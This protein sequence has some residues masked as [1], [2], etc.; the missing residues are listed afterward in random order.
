MY[1][2]ISMLVFT[3]IPVFA[4]E[5]SFDAKTGKIVVGEQFQVD[6]V[7]HTENEE[8]NA[9]EGLVTFSQEFLEL[10]EIRDGNSFVNFWIERPKAGVDG[11]IIFSGITPGGYTSDKGF[12][13]SLIFQA[14]KSGEGVI[15]LESA[16]VLK[17]D[18]QGTPAQVRI[19][20]YQFV[21]RP[22]ASPE[23]Q[24]GEQDQQVS[25]KS[26]QPS[27][28]VI[29]DTEL[30]ESFVPEIV[31]TPVLFEGDWVA[32]FATQDKKSGIHYYEIKETRQRL[33]TF[34]SKWLPAES[35][36]V[37]KDQ[38]L[39][40]SVFVKAVDKAGNERVVK[41]EPR[42]PLAWYEKYENWIIIT[43]AI[44]A[45]FMINYTL[46]KKFKKPLLR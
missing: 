35:P 22:P 13:F 33:F 4:A 36:Y 21:V 10:K 32:V 24:R 12:I 28:V 1:L 26:K 45:L 6:V 27:L 40:S 43:L 15:S 44:I 17:N 46:W 37:V 8:I 7:V 16:R 20:P 38:E 5:I 25:E 29:K 18:G 34:I 14:K 9:L 30:P 11:G 23:F 41:I 39:R 19:S 31:S 2:L 42:N 3:T